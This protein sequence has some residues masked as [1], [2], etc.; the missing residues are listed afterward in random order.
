VNVYI[1]QAGRAC[2]RLSGPYS[3]FAAG[4][5]REVIASTLTSTGLCTA[6]F[7]TFSLPAYLEEGERIRAAVT[8]PVQYTFVP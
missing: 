3:P 1:N 7:Q 2:G 8:T 6:Q 4:E 5:Q